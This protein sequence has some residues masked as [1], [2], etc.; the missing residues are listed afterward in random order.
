MRS[1][2]LQERRD[3]EVRSKFRGSVA[4]QK[5]NWN[6]ALY[7]DRAG[8]VRSVR[9]GGCAPLPDGFELPSETNCTDTNPA[10]PTFGQSTKRIY[11]RVGPFITVNMNVGY[12]ITDSMR[13]NFYVNNVTNATVWNHK[14]PYKMDYAFGPTRMLGVVGREWAMEYVFDF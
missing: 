12:K 6:A 2:P 10:S 11:P 14:D 3:H 8:R 9:F 1:D 5:G 7:G 4:W 13:L